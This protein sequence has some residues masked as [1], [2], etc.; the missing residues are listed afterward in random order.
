M[1]RVGSEGR[2]ESVWLAWFLCRIVTDFAPIA[3][4]QGETA[5]ARRWEEALSGWKSALQEHG[6]DGQWYRRAFFDD[7]QALGASANA[8]C[9]IDLIAQAWAVLSRAST[10][11]NERMAMSAVET[12][13]VD[14]E[15]GL[16]K[17]L[18]PPLAHAE[19]SAGYIQAYPPGVR[20]NGGQYSHAGVWAL[21]AQA[22][23][24]DGDAAYRYF[25]Y[26]SPAHRTAHPT[27]GPAYGIE[28]YVMAGDVYTQPPYVGRGGWSWYTG[29]AAWLYRA[30]IE[31]IFGLQQRDGSLTFKPCLPSHWQHA[32]MTVRRGGHTLHFKLCRPAAT[33]EMAKASGQGAIVLQPGE[34]VRWNEL[35]PEAWFLIPLLD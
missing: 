35:G 29:A 26:L 12:H 18:D 32:D 34:V 25:T 6:W 8:E 9:R 28:P 23:R 4:G 21:M 30:A 31:S 7:G 1:N 19:P 15:A 11:A 33:L 17:L 14:L 27:R 24:G 2:G 13:L 20:E 3:K 22:Q 10:P 5:R 16:I